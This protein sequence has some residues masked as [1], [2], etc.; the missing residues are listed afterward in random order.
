MPNRIVPLSAVSIVRRRS[1]YIAFGSNHGTADSFVRGLAHGPLHDHDGVL[2]HSSSPGGVRRLLTML[3][4]P[5]VVTAHPIG[6]T[7]ICTRDHCERRFFLLQETADNTSVRSFVAPLSWLPTFRVFESRDYNTD[8]GPDRLLLLPPA[9]ATPSPCGLLPPVRPPP[10]PTAP[11]L[12]PSPPSV[13]PPTALPN[14]LASIG[15]ELECVLPEAVVAHVDAFVMGSQRGAR[16]GDPSIR[17]PQR[18]QVSREYLFWSTSLPE[19][20]QW[21]STLY[22]AGVRT[23]DSCGFHVHVRPQPDRLWAFATRFYW[24]GFLTSYR[25]WAQ[26]HPSGRRETYQ[27]RIRRGSYSEAFPWTRGRISNE[28]TSERAEYSAI[29][30]SSLVRH[31]IGAVEHRLLPGQVT[32]E[33]AGQSLDWLVSTVHRLI[34][35]KPIPVERR[36]FQMLA[37][38]SLLRPARE[39]PRAAFE[40]LLR[41]ET[42]ER[43]ARP[44]GLPWVLAD[45]DADPEA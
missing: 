2:I 13:P 33:E 44:T 15:V 7:G 8:G 28:L 25:E 32:A 37:E 3:D 45:V 19:V 17:V 38:A 9:S 34:S 16:H 21:L 20:K 23:N 29:N 35:T 10:R 41:Q 43:S 14:S 30:L 40:T 27:N 4:L 5:N 6:P 26:T 12:G 22:T 39:T 18:G 24:D 42:V 36:E 11:S 1:G 31:G